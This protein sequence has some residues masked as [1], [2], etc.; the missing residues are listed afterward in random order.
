MKTTKQRHERWGKLVEHLGAHGVKDVPDDLLLPAENTT[1]PGEPLVAYYNDVTQV[2]VGRMTAREWLTLILAIAAVFL[3]TE[4]QREQVIWVIDPEPLAA[5]VTANGGAWQF[6][7]LQILVLL[8]QLLLPFL[9]LV[10]FFWLWI[11]PVMSRR[12]HLSLSLEELSMS[13]PDGYQHTQWRDLYSVFVVQRR[14]WLILKRPSVRVELNDGL[15][16]RLLV[17]KEDCRPLAALMRTL[18]VC[19]QQSGRTACSP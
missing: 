4:D 18:I 11:R 12:E 15:V 6:L 2:S 19:H 7:A 9:I 1:R 17:P 14:H 16:A 8:A 3:V 10:G 5:Q 13:L